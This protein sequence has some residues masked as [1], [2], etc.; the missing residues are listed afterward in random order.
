MKFLRNYEI[1]I[2]TPYGDQITINP[3]VSAQIDVDRNVMA[4]ANTASVTVYNLAPS[5]RSKI[6]KDRFLFTEYWQMIIMAGYENKL[7]EIFRGNIQEAYS[8]KQRTEWITKIDGY[9]GMYAIQNGF[10]SETVAAGTPKQDIISR[11]VS[12]MP[13]L[14]EG[15]IGGSVYGTSDRAQVLVG[16]SYDS[17]QQL[18]GGKAYIDGEKLNVLDSNEAIS[19]DVFKINSDNIFETPRRRDT[20]LEV[21]TLFSP[22]IRMSRL[23]QLNSRVT[24][25]NGQYKVYGVKHSVLISE[26]QMGEA[27]TMLSLFA[28]SAPFLLENEK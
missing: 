20:Y 6:Y 2:K 4:S 16:S 8:Y 18:S 13:N 7:Y 10:V 3:P 27:T 5:T 17:I 21:Q 1:R 22:E 23:C 15:V 19:G 11:M 9:D 24:R 12:T 26:A 14:I 28:G 25:Y